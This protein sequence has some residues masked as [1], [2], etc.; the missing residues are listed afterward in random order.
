VR[1]RDFS[2]L[3]SSLGIVALAN[4]GAGSGCGPEDGGSPPPIEDYADIV[5]VQEDYVEFYCGCYSDFTNE[6]VDVC[7]SELGVNAEEE[8]CVAAVFDAYP[9]DFEVARCRAEA[10]RGLV[11]CARAKGCPATFTC[12]DG[13]VALEEWVC[14]GEADCDDGSDEEQDCPPPFMCED[15]TA[16]TESS[17]CDGYEDCTNGED[18]AGCPTPF[19]CGD[20]TEIPAEWVCDEAWDCDD[21]SDEEQDC[22]ATCSRPFAQQLQ[23]CGEFSDEANLEGLKCYPFQCWDGVELPPGTRC[24]GTPDCSDGEDE[25]FCGPSDEGGESTGE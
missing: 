14:D 11:A 2:P 20:G 17:L 12:D 6:S 13:G 3:L 18:E 24:D 19:V 1:D 10:E 22:P 5:D 15:G 7:L 4:A 16:V 23:G 9:L 8:A 25:D 21:G